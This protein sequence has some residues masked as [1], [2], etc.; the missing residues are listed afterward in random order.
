MGQMEM[1]MRPRLTLLCSA[2]VLTACG[3]GG[4][5][6]DM[7]DPQVL[8]LREDFNGMAIADFD[9]DGLND[10]VL[11]STIVEDRQLLDSRVAVY[12]QNSASPGTF[13]PPSHHAQD[14][15][16]VMLKNLAV[17][18]LQQD[19]APDIIG[20]SWHEGGFRTILNDPMQPGSFLPSVHYGVGAGYMTFG[21]SQSI[22]D[23]D[24]DGLP[25][26]ALVSST[27]VS[28]CPQNGA[29]PGT[30]Q[31]DVYIGTGQQDVI[32]DDVDGD[33]LVDIVTLDGDG[34]VS[35]SLRL[36]RNNTNSPGQ[37]QAPLIIVT[38]FFAEHLGLADFDANG[39]MD[40]AVS[41]S[42]VNPDNF[43]SYGEFVVFRQTGP[44]Q[45]RPTDVGLTGGMGIT[46]N[47]VTADLN[48]NSFPEMVFFLPTATPDATTV[49][50]MGGGRMSVPHPLRDLLIPDDPS[51]TS[52]GLGAIAVADLNNDTI[53][54]IAV[55]SQQ[56]YVFF[57][58][59][60]QPLTFDGPHRITTPL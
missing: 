54:D 48:G 30:F 21:R 58:S 1:H 59:P 10:V 2:L 38:T 45:F 26:V 18:D 53:P 22:G 46:E 56:L 25:D 44:G 31:N 52:S 24:S 43:T 16:T 32:A 50:I 6:F 12:L 19:G 35:K 60:A 29:D 13:L 3:G 40:I 17:A 14:L 55:L 15:G 49:R 23:I 4:G 8:L 57:Q 27:S 39:L 5:Y 42:Q 7:V 47:F 41:G 51:L 20:T 11:G 34:V 9:G 36:Y 37:F 28:W 33:G